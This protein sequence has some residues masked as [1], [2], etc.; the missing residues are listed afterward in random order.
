MA[1]LPEKLDL[2]SHDIAEE[3]RQEL[4]RLFPEIRMEG[5]KIDFERLKLALGDAVF[6]STLYI[7]ESLKPGA[8]QFRV[9]LLDPRT[10]RPAIKLAIEGRQADGWYD[11]GNIQVQ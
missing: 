6:D 5:A 4:L 3:K 11:L 7:P 8:C 2:Q 9:G 10:N 1:D